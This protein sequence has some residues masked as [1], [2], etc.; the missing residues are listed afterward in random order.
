M[1]AARTL[2]DLELARK[3]V[4]VRCDFNVP[5]DDRGRITDDTRIRAHLPTLKAILA[6]GAKPVCLS[7][8]GRPKGE[9]VDSLRLSGVA[10]H[11]EGLLGTPVIALN[12]SVGER[13]A[14]AI[15]EAPAGTTV[16][17]ENVRFHAGE[18]KGDEDLSRA[19]AALGDLFVNDAFGTSH[20][21]HCSVSGIAAHLPAAAGRLLEAELAA[22][23]R[24][25][26]DPER[27]FVAVLG[28]AKV[29]DKLGVVESLLERVEVLL[30]G[31]GMAY[32]FL[33]AQGHEIGSS[34]FEKDRVETCAAALAK[35][36]E[37][38]VELVLPVD[39]V[40][41]D[42][43]AA[44]AEARVCEGS[45]PAGWMALDIGPRSRELYAS[46]IAGARTV[47]WN[48]PMG[49][50]EMERFRAGTEALARAIADCPG[51]TVVGGG[52]SVAALSLLDLGSRVS[53]VS[54]GG[55]ASLELLEG[56]RLPGVAVLG[57]E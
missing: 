14:A 25:L 11:L 9:V 56:K 32:T 5:R 23:A 44:D 17:L 10:R 3:R 38:G 40:I 54:T 43:F 13:V 49:V 4:L 34:L 27:P 8:L 29:S 1:P 57:A 47:V 37:S 21:D 45:I 30:V 15:D 35:S 39:H 28:G 19:F 46:K 55:G 31:G 41:A 52:D 18:T 53:H 2:D 50:F 16:V 20:R 26:E 51:T 48:G 24:V 12:E 42:R 22:F 33:A 7:H 6:A 36:Q